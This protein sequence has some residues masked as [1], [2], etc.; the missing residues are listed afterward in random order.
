MEETIQ[1][2]DALLLAQQNLHAYFQTHDVKYIAED[3]VFRNIS[4]GETYRGRAEVGAMLHYFYH[5]AF[6]AK[7]DMTNAVV[8]EDKAVVEAVIKGKHIGEIEGIPATGKEISVPMCITYQLKNGLV[9]EANIYM[10]TDVLLKQLGAKQAAVNSRTTYLVRDIFQLKF[11]QYRAAKKLLDEAVQQKLM[12]E[13]QQARVFTD[14]TGDAYRLIFE[15][16]FDSLMD[17]EASL[18]GS[19][20]QEAWQAWY[21]KFKPLVERSHREILKQVM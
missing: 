20:H 15:E 19:M 13:A 12:P 5:V 1:K 8:T 16:G 21:E 17:Y 9:Q 4:T 11:G 10:M 3:A 6:D 2:S 14:F 18:T 7:A